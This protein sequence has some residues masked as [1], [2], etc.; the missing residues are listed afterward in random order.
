MT[1]QGNVLNP[2]LGI[3][4]VLVIDDIENTRKVMRAVLRTIGINTV[5]EAPGAV[6][7]YQLVK[8]MRPD[9][10]F[11][12]WDMPGA[13]GLDFVRF[14]RSR[15][16]SPDPMMPVILLTAHGSLDYVT[17]ARDV[18]ATD[19]LIKPFSPQRIGRR[20]LDVVEGQRFFVMAP[21]YKGPDR[22]RAKKP[23]VND[24]RSPDAPVPGVTLIPPDN[25]LAA[26][27]SGDAAAIEAAQHR[28]I[29]SLRA[30]QSAAD[31][32]SRQQADVGSTLYSLAGRALEAMDAVT[33]IL[34][35]MI[36]PLASL[37]RAEAEGLPPWAIRIILSLQRMMSERGLEEADP[38]ALRLHLRALRAMLRAGS[39]PQGAK[40]A[41][42][43][44]SRIEMLN[45]DRRY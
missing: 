39:D 2:K 28:R 10:V 25:L 32:D 19:F 27:I 38:V 8:T 16:D 17:A 24:Y 5:Y 21:G 22:R 30:L 34:S 3:L 1:S 37:R 11:T 18:G 44:A 13:T 15:P 12:D 20:I 23:V 9:I 29:E 26:K 41:E 4:S 40:I 42:E 33:E 36:D 6:E 35:G 43:L 7:G 31:P 14:V 45:R